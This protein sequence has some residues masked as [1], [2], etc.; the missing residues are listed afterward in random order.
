MHVTEYDHK[1]HNDTQTEWQG[2]YVIQC[3]QGRN[4]VNNNYQFTN[5][6]SQ[7]SRMIDRSYGV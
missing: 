6:V 7:L 4:V 1:P 3:N 2:Q 5:T